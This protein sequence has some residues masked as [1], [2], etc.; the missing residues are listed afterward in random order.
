M[1][2]F[3]HFSR[4]FGCANRELLVYEPP[5]LTPLF[6]IV[7]DI[8]YGTFN[9]E[10]C[11][12]MGSACSSTKL[13]VTGSFDYTGVPVEIAE[14]TFRDLQSA[15]SFVPNLISI[16]L[17]RGEPATVGACWKERRSCDGGEVYLRKTITK[18]SEK[19]FEVGEVF[20]ILKTKNHMP[21]P[22][23]VGTFT[24]RI[25]P[26]NEDGS[27]C[28]ISWTDAF[29]SQGVCA[30]IMSAFCVPCLK[31]ALVYEIEEE[32]Q[33]YYEECLRRT[34]KTIGTKSTGQQSTSGTEQED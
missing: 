26:S 8:N 25:D 11:R 21:I 1:L 34:I 6:R 16:E 15:P 7:L 30:R 2:I 32:M 20:E 17:V 13:V 24:I 12:T 23:F 5:S 9:I 14:E 18:M 22:N 29:L 4:N 28:T 10:Y 31:R 33:H 27:S 19:P 3:A